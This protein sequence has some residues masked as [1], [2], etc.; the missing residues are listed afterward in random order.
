MGERLDD[1]SCE[2]KMATQPE[3]TENNMDAA[4]GAEQET[5]AP[6]ENENEVCEAEQTDLPDMETMLAEAEERGYMRG[7]NESIAE[8]MKKPGMMERMPARSVEEMTDN[9]D[10]V[11][12]LSRQ[13]VSIWDK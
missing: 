6:E 4:E 5:M 1:V 8:L 12:I 3:E 13:R 9:V 10:E 11:M 2:A 7:R